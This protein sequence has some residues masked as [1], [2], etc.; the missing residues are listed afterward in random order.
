M[1]PKPNQEPL[2]EPVQDPVQEP[3]QAPLMWRGMSCIHAW[4]GGPMAK[5]GSGKAG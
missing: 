5:S 3:L 1:A 4:G 2:Q